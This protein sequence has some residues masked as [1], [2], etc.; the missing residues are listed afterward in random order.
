MLLREKNAAIE[1]LT[2]MKVEVKALEK[3]KEK[4]LRE[5]RMAAAKEEERVVEEFVV[6]ER[7]IAAR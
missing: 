2:A 3:L 4:E 7:T 1:K 5:Y 6:F